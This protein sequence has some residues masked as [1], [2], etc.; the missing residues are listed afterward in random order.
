[1]QRGLI[2]PN[3]ERSTQLG[4]LVINRLPGLGSIRQTISPF[5]EEHRLRA[6]SPESITIFLITICYAVHSLLLS[7]VLQIQGAFKLKI[8][9]VSKDP[10]EVFCPVPDR[11]W[12]E[13]P[14]STFKKTS[15]TSMNYNKNSEVPVRMKDHMNSYIYG[16]SKE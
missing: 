8:K 15:E 1:M 12:G 14:V 2:L 10:L 7:L 13:I 6:G 5:G 11:E 4:P 16:S 3:T 9:K